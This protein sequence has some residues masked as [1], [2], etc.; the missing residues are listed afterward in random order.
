MDEARQNLMSSPFSD[1]CDPALGIEPP[2][3][4]HQVLP[5]FIIASC[6]TRYQKIVGRMT[7]RHEDPSRHATMA[8]FV[9]QLAAPTS[10]LGPEVATSSNAALQTP[11]PSR[12]IAGAVRHRQVTKYDME[13]PLYRQTF[14]FVMNKDN[15]T[16]CRPPEKGDRRQC[17]TRR[18]RVGEPWGKFEDAVS[19]SEAEEV[20]KST[21]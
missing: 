2:W 15:T 6:S 1:I 7:S 19:T 10:S 3:R 12:G 17:N 13:A 4:R 16:R 21:N 5:G 20:T 9:T 8:N 11:S 18:R 14:A